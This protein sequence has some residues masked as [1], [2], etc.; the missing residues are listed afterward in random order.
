MQN[1][2]KYLAVGLLAFVLLWQGSGWAYSIAFGPFESRAL[3][4]ERLQRLVKD[5]SDK[6]LTL[7]KSQK[8]LKELK[9]ISLP[10]D[11]SAKSK[12]PH[13]SRAHDLYS[14]WLNDLAELC[15]F[16]HPVTTPTVEN[17]K[18]KVYISV[19]VRLTAE[20]RYEQLVKFLD[21]FYRTRLLHR[22]TMLNIGTKVFEGDPP[23]SI[24]LEAEGVALIDTPPRRTLFPQTKLAEDVTVDGTRIKV[25]NTAD[26]PKNGEFRIQIRNEFLHVKLEA[27]DYWTVERGQER[28]PPV[29]HAKGSTVE[30]VIL[31]PNQPDRTLAEFRQLVSSNI[32]VKPAPPYH[33]KV[34][35]PGEKLFTRGK[36]NDFSISTTG[37]DTFLGK[38]K[39]AVVGEAPAGFKMDAAGRVTWRPTDDVPADKY[40]IKYEIVHPSA[41][42]GRL[43]DTLTVRLRDP[44]PAPK[45]ASAKPVRVFLNR[46]WKYVPELAGGDSATAGYTWKLGPN[47]PAGLT[48][49]AQ[50]G[51]L[52]WT[53]GDT[54]PMGE[55]TVAVIATDNDT[56]PQPTTL[57]LK[58][59]VKDDAAQFTRLTTTFWVGENRRAFLYDQ[60]TSRQTELHEGDAV[61]VSDVSGT[62]KQI[63]KR[64][65]IVSLGNSDLRWE[66]G[67]SLRE[68]QGSVKN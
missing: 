31:D 30:L 36:P 33:L 62:V 5:K 60:S 8:A 49:N 32:F 1:R 58:L 37:W 4:R 52:N 57:S 25:E 21:L 47:V 38:P 17:I 27:G 43:I 68:A 11:G 63:S 6:E 44:R 16:D 18:D 42:E 2:E 40:E 45:L 28:T 29:A 41:P 48:I 22:I 59:E 19:T 12:Q 14:Q 26:F 13:A 66:V 9:A 23:L 46:T 34:V 20:A 54:V 67:Q 7:V 10:P 24:V 50:S 39:F 53:P 15:E 64:Y 65:V 51:E 56:P 35:P 3:E 55:T 61:A